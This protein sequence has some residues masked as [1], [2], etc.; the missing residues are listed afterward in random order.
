MIKR[1][2]QWEDLKMRASELKKKGFRPGFD[3]MTA[4][5]A[6]VWMQVGGQK[7]CED[8][9]KGHYAPMPAV[10]WRI[11]KKNGRYRQLSRLTAIDSIV[12][13]QLL[14][15]LTP[16][17][18][19]KFSASSFAYRPGR[20][21]S[22]A[23]ETY[24]RYAARYPYAER[25]DPENCY[26]TMRHEVLRKALEHFTEDEQVRSL[27]M[28]FVQMPLFSDGE[29]VE[30]SVGVLQGAPLSP[31]LCNIYFHSLDKALEEK[32]VPF[33]RYA[34]DIVLF[35]DT[36][37][38]LQEASALVKAHFAKM[39]FSVHPAKHAVDAPVNLEFLNSG[40]EFDGRGVVTVREAEDASDL[41]RTWHREV[42]RNPR[43]MID[44]LSDGILRQKD[45]SLA[46]ESEDAES[47][48]PIETVENIN[49]YSDVIFDSGFLKRA[50]EHGVAV[51]L[52]DKHDR[53]IGHFLPAA[54]LKAPRLTY[55]QLTAYYDEAH[56]LQLARAIVLA[57]L[58]NLR[59]NVRYHRKQ[60]PGNEEYST[61][62]SQ[63]DALQKK[64][65]DC[66]EYELLLTLEAEVR[67]VY[68]GCFDGFLRMDGFEFGKRSRRPPENEINAL[69]SFGNTLLYNW[70]A[71][72][73]NR[74]ALDG[75]IA[76]LHATNR[77]RESLNLDLADI[78]KPLIIDRVALALINRRALQKRHFMQ[79]ENGGVYLTREGK[80][81]FLQAFYEKLEERLMVKGESMSYREIMSEEVGK[82]IRHFR[83]K[84]KYIP[85][86]QVR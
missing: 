56:R 83:G 35:A 25:I 31:L 10:G 54:P 69:L 58:H 79:E 24:C 12:Q 67:K 70:F 75:R 63:L 62:V 37:P 36:M 30:R 71:A 50:A 59:L 44:I 3:N 1:V 28:K 15:V 60:Y 13:M 16:V 64:I 19:E 74:S 51:N 42:P 47:N 41:W 6:V 61:A 14:S 86:K 76:Y 40:F 85:Y 78:F 55:E 81:I 27:T 11:A 9:L 53:L 23:L 22:T 48:I 33:I 38:Q 77:R 73:I 26:D 5:A 32:E 45:F 82:L 65:K 39:G 68:Y 21:A 52:F 7:L 80:K 43:G 18:A 66:T 49:V 4:A 29:M 8:I 72:R 20:S 57:E 2:A 34:D 46:F 84:E 17:C